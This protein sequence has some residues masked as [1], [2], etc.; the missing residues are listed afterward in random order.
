MRIFVDIDE[1]AERFEEL[2]VRRLT[3]VGHASGAEPSVKLFE[4]LFSLVMERPAFP[5]QPSV[6]RIDR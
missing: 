4:L 3:D 6:I 2:A 5:I 1:A